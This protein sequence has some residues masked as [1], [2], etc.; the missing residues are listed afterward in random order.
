MLLSWLILGSKSQLLAP[1]SWLLGLGFSATWHLNLN[2]KDSKESHQARLQLPIAV[3]MKR[4]LWNTPEAPWQ[5]LTVELCLVA[6]VAPSIRVVEQIVLFIHCVGIFIE[7][8]QTFRR[9]STTHA[10]YDW[11]CPQ[12]C[13]RI[14]IQ[15]RPSEQRLQMWAREGKGRRTDTR[16]PSIRR[17]M[18]DEWAFVPT[19]NHSLD[20]LHPV[21]THCFGSCCVLVHCVCCAVVWWCDVVRADLA[22]SGRTKSGRGLGRGR[23]RLY[24]IDREDVDVDADTDCD[25]DWWCDCQY[26]SSVKC[27]VSIFQCQV[28]GVQGKMS[29]V[30]YQV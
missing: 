14:L 28:P 7:G 30:T 3:Q 10:S 15:E 22:W 16:S 17:D 23:D 29:S 11:P 2:V 1:S 4:L 24:V 9:P 13:C 5:A 8:E 12:T 26:P 25:C 27:K 21:L 6:T 20:T 18:L 19:K